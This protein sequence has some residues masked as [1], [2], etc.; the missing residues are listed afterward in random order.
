VTVRRHVILYLISVH[1]LL[2]SLAAVLLWSRPS[3]LIPVE[4]LLVV[5]LMWGRWLLKLAMRTTS[6]ASQSAQLL[7]E[8][9]MM[10]RLRETGHGDVDAL[11][12][13]YNRMT[14]ALRDERTRLQ[15]QQYFLSRILDVSPSGIVIL[16]SDDRFDYVN[17]S[18]ERLL[19]LPASELHGLR[20]YEA[21]S[22][23]GP[24]LASLEPGESR[25]LSV[26]GGRRVRCQRGTFMDRGFSRSF[27]LIEELTEELRQAEKGAYEKVI[28]LLSH[29][30]NNTVTASTSLLSSC[31]TYAG[32]VR[33]Q[34]REDFETALKVVIERGTQLNVFMRGF[35][36]VV[37]LPPPRMEPCDIAE[38]VRGVVRLAQPLGAAKAIEWR[39]ELG[40]PFDSVPLDRA[41]IEQALL[42]VLKNAVEAVPE[43]G[44]VSVRLTSENAR[45]R[46]VIEDNG[47]GLPEDVR[48]QL[49]TPF[50]STRKGGQ[51]IGLTLV[52]EILRQHDFAFSLVNRDGGGTRFTI[53]FQV[54]AHPAQVTS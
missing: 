40:G 3:L 21:R 5:S 51:G 7:A 49:F 6:M 15:E 54:T 39:L 45:P 24:A 52:Q 50:F 19:G 42:N 44:V 1:V 34:D 36:D 32:V 20:V 48:E 41:Q 16:D 2:A 31:L 11:V 9:D 14:D 27:F 38:L 22:T 26:E 46:L 17:P 13:L 28:R 25:V 23:F 29:E 12:N 53:D 4:A 33:E 35:A 30:V 8:G 43:R 18:A 10:T 47:P 37:R